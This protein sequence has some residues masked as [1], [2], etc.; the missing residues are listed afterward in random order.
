[1]QRIA[2]VGPGAIGGTVA[3]W[4]SQSDALAVTVCARTSFDRLEIETP[5]GTLSATVDVLTDPAQAAAADWVLIATKAYDT[6]GVATWLP[7]LVGPETRVAVLQNGVEHVERF[8]H[9]VPAARILPAVVDIPAERTAPGRI[10]QRRD[11][12]IVV[13]S[14]ADGAAFVE[15]F[16]HTRI[17]VTTTADFRS[18]AWR[19]LCRN[20]AGAV[21]ALTLRPASVAHSEP[22]ADIMRDL[23]RECIAVGRAEGA[24]LE[25]GLVHSVI[26]AYRAAPPDSVNSMHADRA[27]GRPIELDARNGVIVRLGLNHGIATPVNRLLVALLAAAA[28]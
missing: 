21:S 25:D 22:V 23:V 9:L 19:K 15:L 10:R 11:G 14:G 16:A 1:M 20:A 7:G 17:A 28:G 2:I 4:L 12:A 13:P 26:E 18:A 24:V 3:A 27:T 6:E 8:Q 5:E